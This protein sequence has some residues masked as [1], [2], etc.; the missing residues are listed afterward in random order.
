MPYQDEHGVTTYSPEDIAM[1]LSGAIGM[2]GKGKN[3]MQEAAV[4]LREAVG[5]LGKKAGKN[6][7]PLLDQERP[8]PKH[9]RQFRAV[10]SVGAKTP[11]V[12]RITKATMR[13]ERGAWEDAAEFIAVAIDMIKRYGATA[14]GTTELVSGEVEARATKIK[15]RFGSSQ[16]FTG[17]K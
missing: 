1:K 14:P 5:L 2:L 15:E 16:E 3:G 11:I 12:E 6:L 7:M 13:I 9:H 10:G 17:G 8:A 4:M